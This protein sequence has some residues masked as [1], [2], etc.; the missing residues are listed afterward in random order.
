MTRPIVSDHKILQRESKSAA[1]ILPKFAYGGV[2]AV[3]LALCALMAWGLGRLARDGDA[4]TSDPEPP[5]GEAW[6]ERPT[7]PRQPTPA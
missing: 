6:I 3:A 4:G 1:G 5:S 2:L 7:D